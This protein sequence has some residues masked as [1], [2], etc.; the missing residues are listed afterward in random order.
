MAEDKDQASPEPKDRR[1][2][3]V[4]A[5]HSTTKDETSNKGSKDESV[6][7]KSEDSFPT[8]DAPSW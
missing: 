6:D 1:E 5:T 4:A 8:S 3:D 7:E 2:Q